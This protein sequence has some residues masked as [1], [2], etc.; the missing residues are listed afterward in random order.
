VGSRHFGVVNISHMLYADDT[1][2]F[3]GSKPDHL[4]YLRT[5]FLVVFGLKINL[6]KE[7][8]VLMDML[9]MWMGWL[10]F[11]ATGF[12]LCL[13][14]ILV[15]RWGPHIRPSLFGMVLLKR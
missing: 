9:I 15:F 6:A 14:S 8:L 11:W 5:L 3:C 13:S 4:L 7:E 10:A 12:L 2:V 1:L